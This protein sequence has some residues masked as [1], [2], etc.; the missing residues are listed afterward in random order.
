MLPS[1]ARFPKTLEGHFREQAE[2]IDQR[3]AEHDKKWERRF[4]GLD[5]DVSSLKADASSLKK[6]LVIVREGLSILLKKE[7]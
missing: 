6:D 1:L 2:L 3:F 7:S 4:D 5:R